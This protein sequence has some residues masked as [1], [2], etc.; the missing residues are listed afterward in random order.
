MA[1]CAADSL[2][3][4][5]FKK[6]FA[7]KQIFSY[8]NYFDSV[9]QLWWH[10]AQYELGKLWCHV[11]SEL[12]LSPTPS[13]CLHMLKCDFGSEWRTWLLKDVS[14][15]KSFIKY[16]HTFLSR[17]QFKTA[18]TSMT[19]A[20]AATTMTTATATTSMKTATATTSM[21]TVTTMKTPA[22]MTTTNT[23]IN[24]TTTMKTPTTAS[25]VLKITAMS[26]STMNQPQITDALGSGGGGQ[27]VSSLPSY[28]EDPS[29]IPAD[30]YNFFCKICFKRTKI[31]QKEARVGP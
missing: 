13:L 8:S 1:F 31:N 16:F 28:S 3:S 14:K 24:A 15:N 2:E 30:A 22:T 9:D 25:Q 20:T 27:E 5:Y 19:T 21:K 29:S 7:F 17:Q 18:T 23:A 26:A 6:G 4:R 11:W 10:G 12:L